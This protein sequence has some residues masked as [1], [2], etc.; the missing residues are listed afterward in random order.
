[1]PDDDVEFRFGGQ[2]VKNFQGDIGDL[3]GGRLRRATEFVGMCANIS[4]IDRR[5][6]EISHTIEEQHL[7]DQ[8]QFA[9]MAQPPATN[10]Q[11]IFAG[12]SELKRKQD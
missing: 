12:I 7:A 11:V 8:A 4:R 1:M 9:Q 5:I 3:R 10:L 6:S 2:Q